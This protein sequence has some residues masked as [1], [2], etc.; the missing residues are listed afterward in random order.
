MQMDLPF[1]HHG[2]PGLVRVRL[3]PTLAPEELGARPAA[4]GLASCQATVEL[5]AGGYLGLLGWVQLVRSTDNSSHGRRFEM[6]P[7]D[8]F[9]LY[10]HAPSPYCWYGIKPTLFDAPSRDRRVRLDWLAHSFLAASPLRGKRPISEP[11]HEYRRIVTPLLGFSWGFHILAE[12]N[13][14]LEP[15]SALTPSDWE[16][17]LP[18]LRKCYKKWQF[19]EMAGP[20]D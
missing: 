3:E 1:T 2:H 18:Y 17:H 7:F 5:A 13:I 10:K 15:I 9:N 11:F 16:S 14:V 6:D 19:H 8:P 4:A 20:G 12:E